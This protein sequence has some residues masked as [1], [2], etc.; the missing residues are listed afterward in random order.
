MQK[1]MSFCSI[2]LLCVAFN[3]FAAAEKA[4][5]FDQHLA[6]MEVEFSNR[7]DEYVGQLLDIDAILATAFSKV[8]VDDGFKTGFSQGYRNKLKEAGASALLFQQGAAKAQAKLIKKVPYQNGGGEGTFR[9]N[10]GDSG[11]GYMKMVLMPKKDKLKVVDWFDYARGQTYTDTL[12]GLIRSVAPSSGLLGKIDDLMNDKARERRQ[13]LEITQLIR[14]GKFAELKSYYAKH[15]ASVSKSW[16][17]M[18]TVSTAAASSGD[19]A[20]YRTVL[21]DV[22]KNFA[23]DERA[24]FILLDYYFYESAF[25]KAIKVLDLLSEK[26]DNQDA[27]TLYLK[28]NLY[29]QMNELGKAEEV[30]LQCARV[31]PDFEDCYW[32]LVTIAVSGEKFDKTVKYLKAIEQTFGYQFGKE[33]FAQEPF[34]KSFVASDAFKQW[35]N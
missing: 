35:F 32:N 12:A 5:K 8:E 19:E 20:F 15:A 22:S 10:F 3:G 14:G 30:T 2:V 31:E 24:G 16:E 23:N 1:I 13:Y 6:T 7:N 34:Y 25:D 28:S 33:N 26:F 29:V 21:G 4:T 27:G 9:F 17:M 18:S 11:F